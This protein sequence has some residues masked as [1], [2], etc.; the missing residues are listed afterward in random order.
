M[1][2]DEWVDIRRGGLMV[3]GWNR[4]GGKGGVGA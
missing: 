3:Q 2:A 1:R 4:Q